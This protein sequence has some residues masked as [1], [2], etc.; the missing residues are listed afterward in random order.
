[1]KP[2]LGLVR[3]ALTF[4]CCS[5]RS[6]SLMRLSSLACKMTRYMATATSQ[7]KKTSLNGPQ[8]TERWTLWSLRFQH[9]GHKWSE[10]LKIREKCYLH[11]TSCYLVPPAFPALFESPSGLGWFLDSA[12]NENAT[13]FLDIPFRSTKIF[14]GY[15]SAFSRFFRFHPYFIRRLKAMVIQEKPTSNSSKPRGVCFSVQLGL[16]TAACVAYHIS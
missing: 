5:A 7:V 2:E 15:L 9:L 13:G 6:T 4:V 10:N 1:M 16:A 11:A 12:W 3:S 8:S 14:N